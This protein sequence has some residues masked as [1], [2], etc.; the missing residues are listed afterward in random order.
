MTSALTNLESSVPQIALSHD[1]IQESAID[2][3]QTAVLSKQYTCHMNYNRIERF[4][5]MAKTLCARDFKGFGTGFDTMNG[6][7]EIENYGKG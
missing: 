5:D 7:I 4:S 3:Q 6:V 1:M 2:R